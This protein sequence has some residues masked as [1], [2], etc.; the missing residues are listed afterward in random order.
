MKNEKLLSAIGKIDDNLIHDAVHDAPKKRKPVWVKWGAMAACFATV[1]MSAILLLP[2]EPGSISELPMLSAAQGD[3]GMGSEAYLAY[4]VSE[5]VNGNPWNE[6]LRI[7]TLPVFKNPVTFDETFHIA[8]GAD[9]DQMKLRLL[10]IAD[11]LGQDTRA[12]T[13]T[14]NAPS[15]ETKQQM[16]AGMKK[17]GIEE[18]PAGM[19]APTMLYLE[20]EGMTLTVDQYLT[21][22]V[23]LDNPIS[24]PDQYNFTPHASYEEAA[25]VAEYLKKAYKALIGFKKPQVSISGGDYDTKLR[26]KYAIEFFDATGSRAEQ[27]VNYHFNRVR[28][29]CNEEGELSL[30][31]FVAADLSEKVGDYPI[32][33]AEEAKELLTSG[34]YI[35]TVQHKMPGMEYVQ[36]TE[37]VYRVG[38]DEEYHMP[39][40]RFYVELPEEEHEGMKTYGAYYVP[41]VASEYIAEMPVWDGSFN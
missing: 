18:I 36:K 17:A 29:S 26:Q 1:L 21:V 8:M 32:I 3:V 16:I 15:E 14:D 19:F 28:F 33:T 20:A 2:K 24:L 35:T 31:R 38:S 25:D 7:K 10:E 22:T 13:V 40:Y 30:I 9:Y 6:R 12:L 34:N 4:D 27:V 41:A 5:L 11:R 23:D 39:Y 37:L